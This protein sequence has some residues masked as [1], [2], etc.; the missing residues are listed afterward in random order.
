MHVS[1]VQCFKIKGE[2]SFRNAA[3]DG[4]EAPLRVIHDISDA[5]SDFR[6]TPSSDQTAA[7]QQ[8]PLGPDLPIGS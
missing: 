4:C 7:L 5:G 2:C 6:F 3:I 8:P 1:E